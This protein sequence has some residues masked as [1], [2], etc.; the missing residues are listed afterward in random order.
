MSAIV[1]FPD[2]TSREE[3]GLV[4]FGRILGS[5]SMACADW[6]MQSDW[7]VWLHRRL[8]V[9]QSWALIDQHDCVYNLAYT[10]SI[11][12]LLFLW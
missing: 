10:A 6:A 2:P 12:M 9:K 8:A 4:N 1:L 7:S 3:K 5:C 11:V